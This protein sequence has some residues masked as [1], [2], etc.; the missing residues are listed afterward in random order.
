MTPI[1]YKKNVVIT[2]CAIAFSLFFSCAKPSVEQY[3]LIIGASANDVELNVINDLKNDLSEVLEEQISIIT[4]ADKL[5]SSGTFFIL[6]TPRSNA[7]IKELAF[8]EKITLSTEF[9][10]S[11]GGIWATT[12][13]ANGQNAVVIGGSDIQGLQYAIYDYSK[14]ILGI[15]PLEYWTGKTP[16]KKEGKDIYNFEPR[17][18]APPKVPI[19][20]YFE[21]DVDELANY[22]GKLLEYDWESYTE[23]INSLVRL[24]YNAIQFFDMLGRPEFYVRPEYK[25]L[26]PDYQIDI[27]YLNKMIDYAKLKGMKIQID[28]ELGY[29]IH[30]MD[31]SKAECWSK[32]KEDWITAWRYYLE[33]TPLSKTDIYVLRPRNQVWDWEYKSSCGESKIDVFNDVYKE[34]GALVDEY[35][36][37]AIKVA[38]CYSDGMDMFNEGFNPPK[39]WTVVWSDHGFGTFDHELKDTKG[40]DFGTY[41]HAGYWLNHTVHN[42]YPDLVETVMKDMFSTYE[43]DKYCLVNGQNFRPFLLNL[44]AYSEVC[45]NPET[46]TSDRFYKNWTERYFS[47]DVEKHAVAS[48]QYLHKAQEGRKGYVE[49][50]WEIREA[51][52]YLSNSPIVRPGKTPIPFDYER[53]L[54]D[55]ENTART[56]SYLEKAFFEAETGYKKTD[57]K[58]VF[59]HSYIL[60]PVQLYSDLIAFETTLHKMAQLKKQYENTRD[61]KFLEDAIT[62]LPDAKNKLKIVFDH[63]SSGDLDDKWKDW[64]AIAIRRQNNGFPTYEMLEAIEVNLKKMTL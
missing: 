27:E 26:N 60:L 16:S 47:P 21:N 9:P 44:E 34:F 54:G 7:L 61:S 28:F 64:Y 24:R 22:R 49:H 2:L 17:T 25:K 46:F 36:P 56:K 14:D 59:Y 3:F 12:T 43:A 38:I 51:V 5:P 45:Y 30:P 35:N 32:Y 19:L 58:D 11:R 62:L 55:L 20:A 40:Y 37:D 23:M 39:D 13:L 48:M 15:D 8:Q 52:S 18:I 53:V 6:G 42:P 50:L 10:G 57:K 29:Q 31:E 4:D 63:R 1:I 33:K 41:M